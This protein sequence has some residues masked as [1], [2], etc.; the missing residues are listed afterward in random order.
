MRQL[1]LF[2]GSDLF[3]CRGLAL[4]A[5]LKY[6]IPFF[7]FFL[8]FSSSL[9][10]SSVSLLMSFSICRNTQR[11]SGTN[12]ALR[13]QQHWLD[14]GL[15]GQCCA[16]ACTRRAVLPSPCSFHS[17]SGNRCPP[18]LWLQPW[19]NPVLSLINI[20]TSE[21]QHQTSDTQD[22]GQPREPEEITLLLWAP[23]CG[24]GLGERTE[25]F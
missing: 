17:T 14:H 9:S 25:L 18:S 20:R 2:R 11:R 21:K 3:L 6:A 12:M 4:V 1:L 19:G 7:S 13:E 5:V 15:H 22:W 8:I 10:L 23:A 16:S 24:R